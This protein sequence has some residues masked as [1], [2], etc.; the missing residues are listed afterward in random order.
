MDPR[1][2]RPGSPG[3]ADPGPCPPRALGPALLG[4]LLLAPGPLAAQHRDLQVEF[5]GPPGSSK[6]S[7]SAG[8][9]GDLLLT[10]F[11]PRA[12]KTWALRLAHRKAGTWSTPV[13][14]TE[15]D[16]FFVNW[17]DFPSAVETSDGAW[18]V[19]WLEK[20]EAKPY[21]YHVRLSHSRD[22]GRTWSAPVTA[23]ADRS[24]TEHGFVAM[25]PD[26]NRGA[27]LAWLDGHQMVEPSG[28]MAL[29]VATWSADGSLRGELQLD[30][31]TCE[32]CQVSMA[33]TGGG[34]IA[35]YRDRSDGEIRDI[36]V[37]R[38]LG[39]R[40]S[41]PTVVHR[42]GWE[43]RAC[44]VNGP[45]IDA[46]GQAV[47]VAWF[48][49]AGGTPRVKAAFSTD[50]G[51]TFGRPVTIDLGNPLGRVQVALLDAR[52]AVVFWLEAE[53]DGGKWMA[54]RVTA[55]GA[56]REVELGRT[57]RTREA[58]FGRTVVVGSDLYA[59]WSEPGAEGS[60]RVF[61]LPVSRLPAR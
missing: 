1:P 24:P 46:A 7:L 2:L 37:V 38:E 9:G 40:W 32:C 8:A 53:A 4:L 57:A 21:A 30:G 6:P 29:R 34:L 14:V 26:A 12:E 58:G 31:R 27:T 17:A 18:L 61:R 11:E 19:H 13:T 22:G 60:V 35:A 43:W 33:R 44:P 41:S 51:V 50:G 3:P 20:T 39:G 23:H 49:A 56:A 16:R 28:S 10:W 54:R 59:A 25:V 42:D 36:A 48:T 5:T 55:L 52:T 47:A 15:S 45:D